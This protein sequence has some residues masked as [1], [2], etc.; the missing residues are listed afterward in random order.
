MKPREFRQLYAIPY[1]IKTRKKTIAKLEAAQADGPQPASD[2]VKSSHGEGNACT[3]GHA[4]VSGTDAAFTRREEEIKRLKRINAE[5][6][7]LYMEGLRIIETCDDAM[8][9]W[10]I[11]D[12]C[13]NGRK[14]Q[15]VA[16]ELMEQGYD[17]DAEAV[18]KR[19]DRWIGQNVR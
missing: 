1:D 6:E 19:I 16:V 9:R 15:E 5:K 8:L 3:N 18:R 2:V 14:P 4:M 13:L 11:S 17:I 10:M 7:R 12:V